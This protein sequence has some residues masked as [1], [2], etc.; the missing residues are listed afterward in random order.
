MRVRIALATIVA[1][2]AITT[3]AHATPVTYNFSGTLATTLGGGN[4]VTG[5]FTLDAALATI[6]DW[7]LTGPIGNFTKANSN[8]SVSQWTPA[9]TPAADFVGLN[10]IDPTGL[11]FLWLRFETT[12]GAFDGS[13]FFTGPITVPG[14]TTGSSY[15]CNMAGLPGSVCTQNGISAFTSGRATPQAV[16]AVPEPASMLLL[17]TGLIGM[18]ARRWRNRR[19]GK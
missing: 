17:G 6:T 9:V 12:L 8:S 2:F 11:D 13:T 19:Q 7:S 16:A 10:F 18:G 5:T 14:G 15:T 3:A 4:T 1:L